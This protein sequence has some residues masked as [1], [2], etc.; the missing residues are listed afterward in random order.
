MP[1]YLALFGLFSVFQ[2]FVFDAVD[3][4]FPA[5]IDDVF[6]DADRTPDRILVPRLNYHADSC[7]GA[8]TGIDYTYLVID[9]MDIF[10]G[11]IEVSAISDEQSSNERPPL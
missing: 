7:G 11:W 4:R 3:K 2:Q 5:C 6:R 8:G 9:E 1:A 10:D